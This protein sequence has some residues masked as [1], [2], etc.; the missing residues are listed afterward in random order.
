[1]KPLDKLLDFARR[2]N[3][4]VTSTTGGSHNVGSLHFLGRAIDVRSRT[5]TEAQVHEIKVAANAE[6][7]KVRDERIRP[8]GQKV[9]GGPHLHLE[10]PA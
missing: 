2:H 5:L 4:H 7:I 9:W 6:G 8:A 1:L 10:I 3:L